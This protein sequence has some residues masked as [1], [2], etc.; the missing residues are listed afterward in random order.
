VLAEALAGERLRRQHA[1]NDHCRDALN[2][3]AE[4]RK[5]ATVPAHPQEYLDASLMISSQDSVHQLQTRFASLHGAHCERKDAR[6]TKVMSCA[7]MST[8]LPKRRLTACKSDH[9]YF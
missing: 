8:L 9:A 1:G 3:I 7:A 2:V 4:N 5:V 6:L